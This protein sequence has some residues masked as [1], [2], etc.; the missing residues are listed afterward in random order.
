LSADVAT[1]VYIFVQAVPLDLSI[2]IDYL[3]LASYFP[4]SYGPG[5]EEP[6][7]SFC[8]ISVT[9]GML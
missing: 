4:A 7:R 9:G 6:L 5:L 3:A 8:P 1:L 2:R